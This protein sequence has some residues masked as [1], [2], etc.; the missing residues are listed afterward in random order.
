MKRFPVVVA[1]LAI[2]VLAPAWP[3]LGQKVAPPKSVAKRKAPMPQMLRSLPELFFTF[4]KDW[5]AD[6]QTDWSGSLQGVAHDEDHW[7]FTQ[8][9]ESGSRGYLMK[10]PLTYGLDRG[11]PEGASGYGNV[12]AGV[13]CISKVSIP[14]NPLGA[15][16]HFGDLVH[17]QGYLF[18]PVEASESDLASMIAVFRAENLALVG[19]D[20]VGRRAG[21]CAIHPREGYLLVPS[22]D[23]ISASNPIYKYRV[24]MEELRAADREGRRTGNFLDGPYDNVEL[25]DE[26][27]KYVVLTQYSQGGEFSDD[28]SLLFLNHGRA[29]E[30]TG[31]EG[32][33]GITVYDSVT[34]KRVAHSR[35]GAMLFNYAFRPGAYR[36]EPEGLTWWDLD[37]HPR[38]AEIPGNLHG[39]L[40]VILI[41]SLGNEYFFKHYAVD[42]LAEFPEDLVRFAWNRARVI[43]AGPSWKVKDNEVEILTFASDA[44]ANR[45]IQILHHYRPDSV[46]YLGGRSD[47]AK[48][49]LLIGGRSPEGPMPGETALQFD[50]ALLRLKRTAGAWIIT[51]EG[52]HA[53]G[54]PRCRV[55]LRF[56]DRVE[57]DRAGEVEREARR[58]LKV[59][60]RY[61]FTHIAYLGPQDRPALVYFHR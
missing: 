54:D 37:A 56:P 36:E 5:P 29:R 47:L 1:A 30:H 13:R 61:G 19:Y 57:F 33:E 20:H 42:R 48:R 8:A 9:I 43:R 45:A 23:T 27:G 18:V 7:Y 34:W 2:A 10:F 25:L 24:N 12:R 11:V 53:G 26:C 35:N 52:V 22:S 50:P 40:H 28:G 17:Y 49:Y 51:D 59:I 58:A 32:Q 31:G 55:L 15:N 14:G 60:R 38:R 39:Q 6:C 3:S 21:W 41:D 16:W 46:G 44:D 4:L